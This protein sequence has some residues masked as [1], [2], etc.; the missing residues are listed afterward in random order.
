MKFKCLILDHDDTSV[1][2]TAEIHYPSHVETLRK[3]RPGAVPVDL[4]TWFRKNFNPGVM[5]FFTDELQFTE[6][7]IEQEYAI[8]RSFN[9]R[10]IPHFF[11]GIIDLIKKFQKFG[12]IVAVVSH[13]EVDMIE[14]HYNVNGEGVNPDIIFGWDYDPDKR[15]PSVWPVDQIKVKYN[16]ESEDILMVDDLKPGLVMAQKSN[17]RIAGAGW[18]HQIPEI[19]S[20]MTEHCDYYF[21]RVSDLADFL[22]IRNYGDIN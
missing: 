9:E 4:E 16:L 12:G 6:E 18:G 3:I 20:Y 15:K 14:K 11:E 19:E 17:I 13:S 2:S 22:E 7:E 8:W 10:S 5:E 1:S 21:K